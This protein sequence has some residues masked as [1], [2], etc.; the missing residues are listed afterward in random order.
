MK[1]VDECAIGCKECSDALKEWRIC[2]ECEFH[3]ENRGVCA[4]SAQ[5][6]IHN[7]MTHKTDCIPE[8]KTFPVHYFDHCEKFKSK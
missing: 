5:R 2:S 3:N 8:N 4:I 7:Y 6:T 1:T